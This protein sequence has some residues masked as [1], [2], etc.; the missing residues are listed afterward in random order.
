MNTEYKKGGWDLRVHEIWRGHLAARSRGRILPL[1][2]VLRLRLDGCSSRSVTYGMECR[3]C[4]NGV[5]KDAL[6]GR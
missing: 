6:N 3:K 4:R 2:L 1:R 5:L